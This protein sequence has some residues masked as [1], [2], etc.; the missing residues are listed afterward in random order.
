MAVLLTNI[1]EN[2]LNKSIIKES[3]TKLKNQG[4]LKD[5]DKEEIIE[6]F[7]LNEKISKHDWNFE[8]MK[9]NKFKI[10]MDKDMEE[11]YTNINQIIK[12]ILDK[13]EFINVIVDTSF[14]AYIILEILIKNFD[15]IDVFI[16]EN[17]E[18]K[19]AHPCGCSPE[20]IGY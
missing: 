12:D 6:I 11:V 13:K 14:L 15:I 9:I 10:S 17:N 1:G 16:L 3:F 20:Y 5:K 18:L 7:Y 4:K 19:K 8:G 2:A